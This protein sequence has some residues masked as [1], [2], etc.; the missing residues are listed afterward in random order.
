VILRL[1]RAQTSGPGR[2]LEVDW[3]LAPPPDSSPALNFE[4]A[5]K[6]ELVSGGAGA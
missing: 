5:D 6:A 4:L 1:R 2:R 3:R